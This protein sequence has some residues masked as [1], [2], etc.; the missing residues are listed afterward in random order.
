MNPEADPSKCYKLSPDHMELSMRWYL[1][2]VIRQLASLQKEYGAAHT[3]VTQARDSE[4][5]GWFGGEGNG[6]VRP[7]TTAFLDQVVAQLGAL[8]TDQGSLAASLQEY[9]NALQGHIDWAREH[10]QECADRFT[11]LQR[12]LGG[13]V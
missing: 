2:P 6:S 1:D 5:P 8:A 13:V 3:E 7:A 9:R 4:A 11:S 10:E 12:E